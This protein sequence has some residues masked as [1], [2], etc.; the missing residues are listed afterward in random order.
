MSNTGGD[1]GGDKAAGDMSQK[2]PDYAIH[3]P[4]DPV[5]NGPFD[6][7]N[8]AAGPSSGD[9]TVATEAKKKKEGEEG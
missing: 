8:P 4:F 1:K 6:P 7:P 3:Y 9:Y 5:V 2:Q